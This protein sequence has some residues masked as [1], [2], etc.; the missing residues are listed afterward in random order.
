MKKIGLLIFIA[1][2]IA[3]ICLANVFSTG[4]LTG[5][6]F[7]LSI[8]H[9]VNGSGS[10]ASEKRDLADFT[11]IEVSGV[12]QVEAIAGKDYSVEVEADDNLLPFV[13]TEV[14][15]GVLRLKTQKSISTK[16]SIRVRVTAPDIKSLEASGAS[17][18]SLDGVSN[19]I[20]QIDASGASKITVSGETA[21][22]IIDVSGASKI[23]AGNMQ[24]EN[25]TVDAS[26]ASGVT[27]F[28][29]NEL[30]ADASGASSIVYAGSPKDLIKKTSG[31]SSVKQK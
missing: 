10:V 14:S 1:A 5:K 4:E 31:A 30:K 23:D 26:G 2:L 19:E 29:A 28:A 8:N 20:F 18:V 13:I 22:L 21:N 3:G 15:G 27:V 17:K 6:G 7:N 11:E 16:N 12:V 9:S 24:S 25:A